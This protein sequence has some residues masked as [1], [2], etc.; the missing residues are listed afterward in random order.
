MSI[1]ENKRVLALSA[2]FLL[3]FGGTMYYGYSRT[4]DFDAATARLTEMDEGFAA[5]DGSDNAPTNANRKAMRQAHEQVSRVGKNL[6]ADMEKYASICYGDGKVISPVDFQNEV[7]GAIARIAALAV[8]KGAKV[9]TS[10]ADLGLAQYKNAVATAADVPFR[11][12]Q[13]K[14]VA[15]VASD[16]LECGAPQHAK[17]YCPPLPM[18]QIEARRPVPA[19]PLGFELAFEAKRG[20][21]PAILNRIYNNKE[22]FLTVTG[23]AI[24]NMVSLPG[25]DTYRPEGEAA[26]APTTGVDLSA[27]PAETPAA[28]VPAEARRIAVRKTG[29]SD[30]TVR[31]HLNMQVRYFN[32][33]KGRP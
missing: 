25:I 26:P 9:S 21:L 16:I 10:A 28:E 29:S 19:F 22:Y 33:A 11:S 12:F 1:S 4:A 24:D 31:V 30:E 20:Q 14:A 6:Q 2:V 17:V 15:Q 27:A 5:F 18:E 8:E 13:L 23:I 3:A 32:P 7:R